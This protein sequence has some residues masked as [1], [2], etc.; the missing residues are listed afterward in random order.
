M[1]LDK[2]RNVMWYHTMDSF[3]VSSRIL[4]A[5]LCFYREPVELM[6]NWCNV[7]MPRNSKDKPGCC[8]LH[9][10]N[11]GNFSVRK[12]EEQGIAGIQPWCNKRY[13]PASVVDFSSRYCRIWP[14]FLIACQAALHKLLTW[15]IILNDES[16]VTP[17]FCAWGDGWMKELPIVIVGREWQVGLLKCDWKYNISVFLSFSTSMLDLHQDL[18]SAIHD[19]I[20]FN[21]ASRSWGWNVR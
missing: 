17:R 15:L 6:E 16:M 3:E 2:L 7:Y 12:A 19:S 18:M 10:L 8:V 14:I 20:L 21:A 4:K 11:L 5:A 13:E 9:P 1:Q